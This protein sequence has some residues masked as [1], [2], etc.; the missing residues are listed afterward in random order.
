M[1]ARRNMPMAQKFRAVSKSFPAP[2]GGWNA[3]DGLADMKPE[4]AVEL[5]N[6][7]PTN[8]DVMARKGYTLH[9]ASVLGQVESLMVY[10]GPTTSKL[11]CAAGTQIFNITDSDSFLTD[12]LGNYIVTEDTQRLVLEDVGSAVA[13]SGLTNARFQ[14]VNMSTAGGSFLLNVNGADKLRGYNGTSWWT[15]GDGTHDITGVDTATWVNINLH[16]HRVWGIQENTL[17]A[18]YLPIDSIAGAASKYSLKGVARRGGSL[19]A[20]GTWTI[21]AGEGADDM[22]VFVTSQGEVIV[23]RVIDPSN[24]VTWALVGVW[25]IGSPIGHRCFLKFGGDLLLITFDGV[26]QLS[27]ALQSSRLDAKAQLTD[28]I[29]GAMADAISAYSSNF[30]WQL[31]DFPKA[32]FIL[33]NVPVA[34][35]SSQEQYVMNTV[36]GAWT[37]FRDWDANCWALF[38]D[39]IYFGG[40][41]FVAKA[42]DGWYDNNTEDITGSALQAFNYFGSPG[43]TK[44]WTMMR[45]VI[46]TNGQPEVGAGLNVDFDI[47]IVAAPLTIDAG[48][49]GSW[50]SGAWD[51]AIWGANL[52]T[53]Q[54]WQGVT[55]IGKCCAPAMTITQGGL[56]THWVATD[57]VAEPGG[58]L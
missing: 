51:T 54:S 56:E 9:T 28:R 6:F 48:P 55:G 38:N 46:N 47:N 29:R 43:Q 2:I 50:D 1:A 5:I 52:N 13:M 57:L 42:W 45:P 33:L 24:E 44:R 27:K 31:Q 20:M 11:F 21:D 34:T 8:S 22:A 36:T 4:D 58:I 15:D 39:E 32:N 53:T 30:G 16:K 40:D 17:D 25:Q 49:Y 7:F 41:S 19:I 26:A 18:W 12:E 37:K 3:R 14:Y 10:N 23:Y 35:G